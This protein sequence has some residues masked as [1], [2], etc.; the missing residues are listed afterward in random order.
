MQ[1]DTSL[2][3]NNQAAVI[4]KALE[5]LNIEGVDDELLARLETTVLYNCRERGFVV[6]FQPHLGEEVLNIFIAENRNSDDIVVY[7]WLSEVGLGINPPTVTDIPQEAFDGAKY[8]GY[9]D[10]F[11][12]LNYVEKLLQAHNLTY[13]EK[14][15]ARQHEK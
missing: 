4:L 3:L 5:A 15:E 11:N 1:I 9:M 8:F 2:S 14:L 12:T 6:R 10:V 7:D 13:L